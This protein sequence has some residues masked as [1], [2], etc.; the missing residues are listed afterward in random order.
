MKEA[1]DKIQSTGIASGKAAGIH[2]IEPDAEELLQRVNDFFMLMGL[3]LFL[4]AHFQL[5]NPHFIYH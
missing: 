1:M 4:I 2:V 3:E 5:I